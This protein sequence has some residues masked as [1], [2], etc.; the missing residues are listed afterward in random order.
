MITDHHT[1][2]PLPITN[3]SRLLSN[4]VLASVIIRNHGK[5]LTDEAAADYP[6][7]PRL[8][9]YINQSKTDEFSNEIGVCFTIAALFFRLILITRLQSTFNPPARTPTRTKVLHRYWRC[10]SLLPEHPFGELPGQGLYHV[11]RMATQQ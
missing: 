7:P 8:F 3:S 9:T 1:H 10:R 5:R 6:I 2:A 4:S 11:L